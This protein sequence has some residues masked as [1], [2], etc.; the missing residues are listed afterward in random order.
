MV[1]QGVTSE[2]VTVRCQLPKGLREWRGWRM[3][4][5]YDGVVVSPSFAHVYGDGSG[6]FIRTNGVLTLMRGMTGVAKWD[7]WALDTL[8]WQVVRWVGMLPSFGFPTFFVG[9]YSTLMC[10]S[11]L[12]LRSG[13]P[14]EDGQAV[15]LS[16]LEPKSRARTLRRARAAGARS[17]SF[18]A[19]HILVCGRYSR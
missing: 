12:E 13:R 6:A 1:L 16:W 14:L 9:S 5:V 15:Q 2:G 7:G 11:S 8:Q 4:D 18:A 10:A 19:P 17:L 3:H